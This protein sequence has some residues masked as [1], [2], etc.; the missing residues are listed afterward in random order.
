MNRAPC[1]AEAM[2][3]STTRMRMTRRRSPLA[4]SPFP[5]TLRAAA[6]C[7][8]AILWGSSRLVCTAI[9]D[10]RSSEFSRF[11]RFLR[12]SLPGAP[13]ARYPQNSE[14]VVVIRNWALSSFLALSAS[15][16]ILQSARNHPPA[17][18]VLTVEYYRLYRF[19]DFCRDCPYING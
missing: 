13:A 11:Y 5:S 14:F 16:F 9:F 2:S 10:I 15:P 12:S 7:R 17:R 1:C 19:I 8:T 3:Q 6:P 4:D 18:G